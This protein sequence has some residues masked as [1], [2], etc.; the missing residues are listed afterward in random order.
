MTDGPRRVVVTGIGMVCPMGNDPE[1]S[2]SRIV[3]GESGITP[4]TRF[5]ASRLASRIAGEVKGFDPEDYI[6]RRA[7]RRMDPYSHYAV[8]AAR[9][10]L[11]DAGLDAVAE[12]EDI[13]TM[14]G[15][16]GGG[17]STFERQSRVLFEQGPQR[18]SPFFPR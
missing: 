3:A 18:M 15:C 8:A 12:A 5:D 10:A 13:G 6:D 7:A 14:V 17:L 1:T 16:G 2:W 4:I 9:Q 11:D